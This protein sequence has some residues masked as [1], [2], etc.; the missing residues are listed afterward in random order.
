M[1]PVP[2][3]VTAPAAAPAVQQSYAYERLRMEMLRW[4]DNFA[5]AHGRQPTAADRR[6]S[7]QYAP[8]KKQYVALRKERA[9]AQHGAAA[10]TGGGGG[11]GA[12]D[13]SG[14]S[15][16]G[17]SS[18]A[19][20][21]ADADGVAEE[22]ARRMA[23]E[24][25]LVYMR[26]LV[27]QSGSLETS[28]DGMRLMDDAQLDALMRLFA[29]HDVDMDGALTLTEFD[30]LMRQL[31]RG[32]TEDGTQAEA[33]AVGLDWSGDATLGR[34]LAFQRANLN[35]GRDGGTI[36]FNELVT[37][38]GSDLHAPASTSATFP[39]SS[40]PAFPS[41]SASA[42]AHRGVDLDGRKF[43]GAGPR[44]QQRLASLLVAP[45]GGTEAFAV[46]QR[47]SQEESY[48]A[49]LVNESSS[50][51]LE[52]ALEQL[53]DSALERAKLLF[54]AFDS[55]R[56]G[57]LGLTQFAALLNRAARDAR[58]P[59]TA[60][61]EDPTAPSRPPRAEV[62]SNRTGG[63]IGSSLDITGYMAARA[64]EVSDPTPTSGGTAGAE[65]PASAAAAA[66][67][68]L[69]ASLDAAGRQISRLWQ[70]DG[71]EAEAAA[72]EADAAEAAAARAAA[73]AAAKEAASKH[74]Q[75]W[76][77]AHAGVQ[78]TAERYLPHSQVKELFDFANITRKVDAAQGAPGRIDFNEFVSLF[79]RGA[80]PLSYLDTTISTDGVAGRR[81]D[82]RAVAARRLASGGVPLKPRKGRREAIRSSEARENREAHRELLLEVAL[83]RGFVNPEVDGRSLLDAADGAEEADLKEISDAFL[84]CDV[85]ADGVLAVTEFV[86]A[87]ELLARRRGLPVPPP[88]VARAAFRR[89]NASGGGTGELDFL[90]WLLFMRK[91]LPGTEPD[92]EAEAEAAAAAARRSGAVSPWP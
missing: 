59:G 58:A 61:A 51:M 89:L 5:A 38:L 45:P 36:D 87:A 77:L 54:E 30:A 62:R 40:A 37:L 33:E 14:G 70:G 55:E 4:D 69:V 17:A 27:E 73:R 48:D 80:L 21:A 43:L 7:K 25:R 26:R 84:E 57:S 10:A 44:G 46:R 65:A 86:A 47:R 6:A 67:A 75:R 81:R 74:G 63:R 90:Q 72:A 52:Y 3:A 50:M 2:A 39:S 68:S 9:R 20:S 85:N 76:R 15:R 24:A 91:K 8:L 18:G 83:E 16:E 60:W 11:D 12:G 19:V 23:T 49:L 35:S 41:A 82:L 79:A 42:T 71:G 66:A 64:S 1:A 34:R 28:G 22:A 32:E 56:C 29:R 78:T 13:A 88:V 53:G 92:A 31:E